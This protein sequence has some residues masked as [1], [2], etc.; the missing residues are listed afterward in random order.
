MLSKAETLLF[1]CSLSM[2]LFSSIEWIFLFSCMR[3]QD[4]KLL[5][6]LLLVYLVRDGTISTL[7]LSLISIYKWCRLIPQSAVFLLS[8]ALYQSLRDS[9]LEFESSELSVISFLKLHCILNLI[10]LTY[11]NYANS[12]WIITI[13]VLN[14]SSELTMSMDDFHWQLN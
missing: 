10:I 9:E 13:K 2:D 12:C 4:S 11:T 5:F 7:I 3:T 6:D 14:C 1:S 8:I